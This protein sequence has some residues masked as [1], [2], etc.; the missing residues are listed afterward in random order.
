MC[1]V[2]FGGDEPI[3]G[4]GVDED[5]F[6]ALSSLQKSGGGIVFA[7]ED[8]NSRAQELGRDFGGIADERVDFGSCCEE[9][10]DCAEGLAS[11]CLS[12]EVGSHVD[13]GGD[14]IWVDV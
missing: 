10:V 8:G 11:C 13:V 1:L 5:S 4:K 9:R 2:T 7:V 14:L 3:S 6:S 12:D